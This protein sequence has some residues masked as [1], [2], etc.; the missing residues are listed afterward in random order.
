[1][2][3][4]MDPELEDVLKDPE[5]L[6]MARLLG[7]VSAPEPPL[8]DAFR[9]SLRRQLME[10]AWGATEG[11]AS[12]WRR[13]VSPPALTWAGAAAVVILIG[14]VVVY[15]QQQQ[16]G[17]FTLT[18]QSPQ[19][20][21]GAV[22]LRQ[23]IQVSF[24]QPMDHKSTEA[25]VQITP[26]TNVSFTWNGDSTLYVTPTGGDLAPNT[27]YQVT[28]GSG[29]MTQN[30]QPLFSP[31]TI[32][33][34]TQSAPSPAPQPTPTPP[35]SSLGQVRLAT[36]LS[37]TSNT[38]QWSA[39]S[40]TVYFVG[41]G[42]AL[43][44]VSARGGD[45][46]TVVPD[47]VSLPAIAPAG[48]RIAYLRGGKIVILTIASGAT[49]ELVVASVPTMVAWVKDKVYWGEADGVFTQGPDGPV[50]LAA[51]PDPAGS[52]VSI[53][54]DGAH[55][56]FQSAHT[57]SLV[58]LAT[59]N[60]ARLG[61]VGD[62]LFQGWSP[63]GSRVMAGGAIF[64]MNGAPISS[65]P[66]SE[67]SWSANNEIL[68]GGDTELI[69]QRPDGTGQVKLADG[70]YRQPLWAPDSTTF[71]Y[72]R[73]G[74]LWAA[75]APAPAAIPTA[76][77][78]ASAIVTDFMKA[79]LAGDSSRAL[80]FLDGAGQAAYA[81]GNPAL[82]PSSELGFTRFFIVTSEADPT[83]PSVV[84]V[85]VRLVFK[86][87]KAETSGFDETLTLKRA[88]STDPFVIDAVVAGGPL[89]LGK[90]PVVVAV[91]IT[92]TDVEV[93][94]DSD[95]VSTSVAG[96]SL[97]DSS[98][99]PVG[100]TALYTHRTVTITGLHLVPGAHYRLV[101]LP[102]V[103]DVGN[104]QLVTEYDLDLI[105]PA[106]DTTSGAAEPPP[107]SPSPSPLPSASPAASPS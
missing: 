27:Q 99:S 55:A 28:I 18:V 36:I 38:P 67:V 107:P 13:L 87:D 20:D 73:G 106:A 47:G 26:A 21:S 84:R 59:G 5:L 30:G 41:A 48:D 60:S 23:P 78:A 75:T 8:D 79:R 2:S 14:S 29:A 98:G 74:D 81:A 101:V 56:V 16:P 66:R 33:F 43:N 6:H 10:K 63:D 50:K 52:L 58:D 105:G 76:I 24:N 97:V 31:K 71:A 3:G 1:M 93:T 95:L 11:R 17:G 22:A 65:V 19:Q 53:A 91:R 54:P 64:D 80:R 72:L 92:A 104:R 62:D 39:D 100:G 86:H 96:V 25:A 69:E 89:E 35:A 37:G 4:Q 94:F 7:S 68:V 85:V 15:T 40:T 103:Q 51:G 49:S 82:I 102:S 12:W 61:Q 88:E 44:A 57:L 90:G 46:R 34:V 32:T 45:V 77:D 42:G 70:T 83:A 9:S